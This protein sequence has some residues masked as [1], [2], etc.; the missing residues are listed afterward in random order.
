MESTSFKVIDLTGNK[1]GSISLPEKVFSCKVASKAVHETV[2]W[3]L[4]KRRSGNHSTLRKG[5][6]V[7]GSRKPWRQKGTGRARAGD[8][9]SPHWVGGGVAHGPQPRS[10]RTR[11]SKGVR[12]SALRSVLSEKFREENFLIL[13]ELP[14]N[15][16]KTKEWA[17][18][19][20]NLGIDSSCVVVF[21]QDESIVERGLRNLPKVL[22]LSIAG[23]NVYDLLRH[24]HIL[25]SESTAIIL[26]MQLSSKKSGVEGE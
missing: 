6:I 21:S 20:R 7:G 24:N 2:V 8:F 17:E 15:F 25:M 1:V 14:T 13:K 10:Y 9:N 4:A 11:L 26:S 12:A 3:Q 16:S 23:I 22:P 5:D 19:L 18:C